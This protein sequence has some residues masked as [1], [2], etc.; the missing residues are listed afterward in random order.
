MSDGATETIEAKA[1]P[2]AAFRYPAF[3]NFQLARFCIVFATEMQAVAVGWQVYEITSALLTSAWSGSHS[4]FPACCFSLFQDMPPIAS[5][6][7]N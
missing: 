3:V 1:D 6:A 4:F 2:R 5:I 7:A